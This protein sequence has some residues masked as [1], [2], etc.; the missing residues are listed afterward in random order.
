MFVNTFGRCIKQGKI[1]HITIAYIYQYHIF[2]K[3]YKNVLVRFLSQVP[4]EP[5]APYLQTSVP[6]PKSKQLMKQMETI[7]VRILYKPFFLLKNC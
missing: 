3:K 2:T 6:G 5:S 4:G 1:L 7:Q